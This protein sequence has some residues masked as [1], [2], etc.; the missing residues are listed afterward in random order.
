MKTN[1]SFSIIQDMN[2]SIMKAYGVNFR[3]DDETFAKYKT[4]GVDLDVNNVNT[5][6]TLPVSAT[7]I[8][9]PSG[10]IKFFHFDTNYQKRASIKNLLTE[11]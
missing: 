4:Y 7:Y 8:I 6:H 2:D 5:R 10:K 11:L 9:G 3:M 1:V